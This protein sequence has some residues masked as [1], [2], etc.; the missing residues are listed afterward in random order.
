MKKAKN[1]Q[2]AAHQWAS[3]SI[4]SGGVGNVTFNGNAILSFHWWAMASFYGKNTVFIRNWRYSSFTSRHMNYVERAIPEYYNKIYCKSIPSNGISWQ[5]EH[6]TNIQDY[7]STIKDSFSSFSRAYKYKQWQFNINQDA[8]NG[9]NE[10]A[11][12]F[13]LKTRFKKQI[14][15]A[16][17]FD[18][19]QAEYTEILAMQAEKEREREEMREAKRQARLIEIEAE[20]NEMEQ[21]WV[22]GLSDKTNFS[23]SIIGYVSFKETRLRIKGE[24]VQTSRNA[25]V[26][27][28]EA[29]ILWSRI[30]AGKDIKGFKIGYYTVISINGTLKIGCHEISREELDRFIEFYNW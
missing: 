17:I 19:N 16:K 12:V 8:F 26:P 9:L 6:E 22:M 15:E 11:K 4:E 23:D 14:N 25:N 28:R 13:K 7:L 21:N 18:L 24:E 5:G 10:Y 30:K 3:R 2:E 29:K 20:I 1:H 27:I